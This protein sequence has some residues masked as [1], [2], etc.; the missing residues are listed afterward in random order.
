MLG[1]VGYADETQEANLV[2]VVAEVNPNKHVHPQRCH[3][4]LH[5]QVKPDDVVRVKKLQTDDFLVDVLWERLNGESGQVG[6]D[7]S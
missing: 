7:D 2:D 6:L 3:T 1:Q 4:L 5:L